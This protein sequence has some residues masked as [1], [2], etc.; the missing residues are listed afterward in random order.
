LARTVSFRSRLILFFALIVVVPV[1]V[2]ALGLTRVADESRSA[3]ADAALTPAAETALSLYAAELDSAAAAAAAAGRDAELA[4]AMRA[5]DRDAAQR[6]AES[7]ARRLEL[8]ALSAH[9]LS[10]RTLA[11]VGE[12]GSPG[13]AEVAVDGPNGRLGSVSAAT[14]RPE[15]YVA[16]VGRLTGSDVA[17][18]GN[19][20]I[21][22]STADL[23]SADLPSGENSADVELAGGESRVVTTV[24][25]GAEPGVRIAMF[26][27]SESGGLATSPPFLIGAA[28]AFFALALVFVLLLV[29]ALGGQVREMLAAAHRIGGGDFSQR[30]PVRGDDE[31]AGLARE[32]NTM[33]ER[34]ARQMDELRSQ[35]SELQRSV[36]RT[37]EAFAAGGDRESVLQVAADAALSACDADAARV[38]VTGAP[39]IE[40]AAGEPAPPGLDEVLRHAED[41]VLRDRV[42]AESSHGDAFAFGLPVPGHRGTRGRRAVMAIART[43]SPF[44]AA[45]RETLRWFA[46][47]VAVALENIELHE[48]VLDEKAPA[49]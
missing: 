11:D 39:A 38:I 15:R 2:V 42:S 46:G 40:V 18:L 21:V 48:L 23:A 31:L 10:G 16:R 26:A 5:R 17:L 49:G 45:Q 36:R 41:S 32:F 4:R 19:D 24:P 22:A 30:V 12:P 7:L 37:G 8:S 13:S 29:R 43:K 33:S 27:P 1:I 6:A 35:S 47:Q 14:L 20:G 44:D 34:L 9:A 25:E 3:M 28:I